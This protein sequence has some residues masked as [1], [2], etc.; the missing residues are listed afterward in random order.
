MAE[1]LRG[2]GNMFKNK[3]LNIEED[4][5]YT[6][7][8]WMS[9]QFDFSNMDKEIK[10]TA[11]EICG[12]FATDDSDIAAIMSAQNGKFGFKDAI[13]LVSYIDNLHIDIELDFAQNPNIT[14]EKKEL[15]FYVKYAYLTGFKAALEE[16]QM[17]QAGDIISFVK[18]KTTKEKQP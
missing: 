10:T 13:S 1:N 7:D 16:L 2:A 17:R 3:D 18:Q 15:Y 12:V 6:D 8:A 5:D 14:K 4:L 11:D 9:M